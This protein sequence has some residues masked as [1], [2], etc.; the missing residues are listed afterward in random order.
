L[1]DDGPENW[2][3][4]KVEVFYERG[5]RRAAE[6]CG[7]VKP[8]KNELMKTIKYKGVIIKYKGVIIEVWSQ[9][10]RFG[11]GHCITKTWLKR[12]VEESDIQH[13]KEAIDVGRASMGAEILELTNNI[14]K[15]TGENNDVV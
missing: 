3:L 5:V 11:I 12:P 13:V 10:I 15:L 9:T 2:T 4:P 1:W 8:E 7:S 14:K 6:I